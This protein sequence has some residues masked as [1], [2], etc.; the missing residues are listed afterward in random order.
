[1]NFR[2]MT[3]QGQVDHIMEQVMMGNQSGS[4]AFKSVGIG[5]A[6]AY[7]NCLTSRYFLFLPGFDCANLCFNRTVYLVSAMIS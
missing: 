1:M 4:T 3:I 5:T 2:M 7:C 6:G